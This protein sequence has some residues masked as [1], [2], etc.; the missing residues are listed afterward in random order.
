[1]NN[2]VDMWCA[3]LNGGE[4]LSFYCYN[5]VRVGITVRVGM[6]VPECMRRMQVARTIM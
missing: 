2:D 4:F 3:L 1:M 5:R 6:P